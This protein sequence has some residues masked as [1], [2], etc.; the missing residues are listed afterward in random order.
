MPE[1]SISEQMRGCPHHFRDKPTDKKTSNP[2]DAWKK[3]T[4]KQSKIIMK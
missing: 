2:S 1:G 3:A 4:K